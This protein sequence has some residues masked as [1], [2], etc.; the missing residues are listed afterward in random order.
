MDRWPNMELNLSVN[1]IGQDGW[2]IFGLC[3]YPLGVSRRRKLRE[4]LCAHVVT[5]ILIL[6]TGIQTGVL[7]R[8]PSVGT[9]Q[10]H[11][12]EVPSPS[13]RRR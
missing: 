12:R 5:R 7:R 1:C 3:F 13:S 9:I 6:G 8:Q 10:S 11:L 2:C 4:A